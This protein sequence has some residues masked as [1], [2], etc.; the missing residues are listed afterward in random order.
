MN[1][2]EF[3]GELALRLSALPKKDIEE[4][5][6]FYGEMIDDRVEEGLPEE[7][8]VAGVGDIGKIA[9]GIIA[10]YGERGEKPA[11]R[12][13][14]AL[15]IILLVLASPLLIAVF[16]VVLSFYI[17]VWSVLISLWSVVLSIAVCVP[18]AIVLAFVYAFAGKALEFTALLGVAIFLAGL[19]VVS[20]CGCKELTKL[21]ISLTKASA[22][23]IG[24]MFGRKENE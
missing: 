8:A 3:L 14:N 15:T 19:T 23:F 20:Y 11:G 5:L 12:K 16:S 21:T 2:N 7:E 10:E 24:K 6:A 1:K 17:T 9:E 4:R 18:A 22:V 13:W